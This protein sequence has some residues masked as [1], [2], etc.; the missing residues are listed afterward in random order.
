MPALKLPGDF[1]CP[2]IWSLQALLWFLYRQTRSFRSNLHRSERKYFIENSFEKFS[3]SN[4]GGRLADLDIVSK[5]KILSKQPR[6]KVGRLMYSQKLNVKLN[7]TRI[8]YVYP[9]KFTSLRMYFLQKT[10]FENLVI[11]T[12]DWGWLTYHIYI[13]LQIIANEPFAENIIPWCSRWKN[14]KRHQTRFELRKH[15]RS[16]CMQRTGPQHDGRSPDKN[17]YCIMHLKLF[18]KLPR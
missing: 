2:R 13:S 5:L 7:E 17:M 10:L 3:H 11:A 12:K 6:R 9:C 14:Q 1:S 15:A 4:P 16:H 18:E 8:L